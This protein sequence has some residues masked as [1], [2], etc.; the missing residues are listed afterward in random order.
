M[1]DD[2]R[3]IARYLVQQHG[4]DQ[5]RAMTLSSI[6]AC[7]DQKDFYALSVWREVRKQLESP[8]GSSSRDSR[9]DVQ[10]STGSFHRR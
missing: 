1:K 7:Q 5:A 6:L 2:P 8:S 4:L 3:E 9:T 10:S